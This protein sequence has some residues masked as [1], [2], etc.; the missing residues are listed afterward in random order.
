MPRQQ[1]IELEDNRKLDVTLFSLVCPGIGFGATHKLAGE[2]ESGWLEVPSNLCILWSCALAK[3][4]VPKVLCM[5][6]QKNSQSALDEV[7]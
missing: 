7:V 6:T 5:F 2:K 3:E 1:I 4:K